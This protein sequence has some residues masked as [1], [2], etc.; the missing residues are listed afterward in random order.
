MKTMI[1]VSYNSGFLKPTFCEVFLP[2]EGSSKT[3][4]N[5]FREM[6]ENSG[7]PL[8]ISEISLETLFY[9]LYAKHGSDPIA[10]IDVNQFKYDL[11]SRV[12]MYGPA[13]EK[14]LEIQDKI[15]ALSLEEGSD[16]FKGGEAIYNSAKAPGTAKASIID[17]DGKVDYL[18]GQNTTEYKKSKLEG[19]ASLMALIE[20]DVT[21]EF[22]LKFKSLF[23]V[24]PQPTIMPFIITCNE[25]E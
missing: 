2:A 3:S 5:I 24:N 1:N 11:Q 4:Y 15:K 25:E 23:T 8:K 10:G 14:R 9:L 18:D 21:N 12:F 22:L 6:F 17:S 7:I 13:W 19:Y 16:L 20:T